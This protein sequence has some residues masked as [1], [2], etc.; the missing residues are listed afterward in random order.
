MNKMNKTKI[1]LII[2]VVIA[3]VVGVVWYINAQ[4]Y[5]LVPLNVT[6]DNVG[7][8]GTY[9]R[10]A[11]A[12][13]PAI[14]VKVLSP[15]GDENFC[16]GDKGMIR[17]ES[18]GV[19]QVDISVGQTSGQGHIIVYRMPVPG[20]GTKVVESKFTW[21]VGK[22]LAEGLGQ[23]SYYTFYDGALYSVLVA[24]QTGS[25]SSANTSLMDYSDNTFLIRQCPQPEAE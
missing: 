5:E 3:V 8:A 4:E 6:A 7:E 9:A 24:G 23:K 17:V 21:T 12:D 19:K 22:T 13:E 18:R 2:L 25:A 20:D 14:F 16:I 1:V 10:N 15:N 11:R